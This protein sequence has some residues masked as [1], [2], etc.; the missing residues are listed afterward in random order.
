M[1]KIA[2][3]DMGSNSIRYVSLQ[4][5]D[6]KAYSFLN[7]EK[8]AIR[9]GHG[10]SQTGR[11]SEEGMERAMTC[12]HVYK[13]MMKVSNI[14][15]C[16][17][18]ATAAV[19]NAQNGLEF[20]K[21]INDETG[22]QMN[23]ITG[24][25]EAYL[26]YL[27]VAN[28]IAQKDCLIFDLGGASVEM[29]LVH[30][31]EAQHSISIPIGA[32][33]L[34]EKFSL[35]GN[36]EESKLTDCLKYIHK[37]LTA[38]E[39]IKNVDVPL[40]GIGGTARNFAKMDQKATNYEFPKIHNYIVPY[41]NFSSL[42]KEILSR[43]AAARKKIPGLS[44]DRA[45]LIV[46]GAAVIQ[47]LFTVAGSDEMIVSGCGLREGLFF[48]YY[49]KKHYMDMLRVDD[50]LDFSIHNFIGTM[51]SGYNEAH[52]AQVA[53]ITDMLFDQLKELHGFDD[54]KRRLLHTAAQLHDIG[55]IINFYNHARHSAFMI[56]HAPLYGLTQ[57]E[58]II[59]GFIAGFHHGINRK[60]LRAYRYATMCTAEEW[61]MIRKLS[62]LLALAEASDLTYEQLVTDIK[63]TITKNVVVLVLT[64][65]PDA[66][67]N[68]V[69]YEM[70]QL[71][72]QFKKEFGSSLLLV[73]K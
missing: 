6:N 27:G 13:H 59:C 41:K 14:H 66:T 67:Y 37:K 2:I 52:S 62:T 54:R 18:V 24:E 22:I 36:Y 31:G 40:I 64:T 71:E 45:D 46:S 32:V 23:V 47:T 68:A 26:G 72:K 56:A 12:L 39:W 55:K 28:T 49:T 29:T 21:R 9:L 35:Q 8:E 25:R 65:T 38:I 58:Q 60:T 7:Q 57:K 3:I 11:L 10:L 50:I 1:E 34:T 19:R 30:N 53:L 43:T 51:S 70:K 4:I 48:E 42:Y 73:W 15:T 5:A 33:T 61:S 17:A 44:S 69:E 16:L 63:A 20:L